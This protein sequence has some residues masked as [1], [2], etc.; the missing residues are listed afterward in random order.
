[1]AATTSNRRQVYAD[2]L[3][4][5]IAALDEATVGLPV[6]GKVTAIRELYTALAAEPCPTCNP[7]DAGGPG[8]R[9]VAEI[10]ADL[11]AAI[12]RAQAL[13]HEGAVECEESKACAHHPV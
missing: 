9:S 7:V 5:Q 11:D 1:M 12:K 3:R 8:G 13:G 4:L 6:H 2:A 10:R